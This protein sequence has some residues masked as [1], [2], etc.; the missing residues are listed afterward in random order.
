MTTGS[1][2]CPY[3]ACRCFGGYAAKSS[4]LIRIAFGESK[5]GADSGKQEML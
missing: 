1:D 2:A 4:A 5:L 3:L